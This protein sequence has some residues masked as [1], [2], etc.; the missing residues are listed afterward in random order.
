MV[1]TGFADAR[2][3][4]LTDLLLVVTMLGILIGIAVPSLNGVFD[5]QRLGQASR[6]VER[7]LH[8][9]KQRAVANNRPMRLRFN[10]PS[11]GWFRV[12]ELI[13]TP[14][15]PDAADAVTSTRRCD[16]AAYPFPAGDQDL[17]TRPNFD[18]APKQIDTRVR[19]GTVQTIE[20]WPDGTARYSTGTNP[21]TLI[22]TTGVSLTLSYKGTTSTIQV[23]GLGRISRN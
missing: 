14:S 12:V 20:F 2:G 11:T 21:W 1:R 7:E 23:N 22:P 17:T 16:T 6:E 5:R 3:F 18:G 8:V 10:C 13:G 15:Q 9:A 19:F 4:T